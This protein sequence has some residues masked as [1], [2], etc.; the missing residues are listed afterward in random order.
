[1]KILLSLWKQLEIVT[2][3][4]YDFP[5]LWPSWGTAAKANPS[6]WTTT[7]V[8]LALPTAQRR[9]ASSTHVVI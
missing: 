6:T 7:G 1:M 2:T 9:V 3:I 8:A 4:M 5:T